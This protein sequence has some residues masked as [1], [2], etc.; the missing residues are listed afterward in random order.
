MKS[1]VHPK[2]KTKYRVKNWASYDRALVRRGDVTVWLSPEEVAVLSAATFGSLASEF[3]SPGRWHEGVPSRRYR[4]LLAAH[5]SWRVS[6]TFDTSNTLAV[7]LEASKSSMSSE[8]DPPT[9]LADGG[10]ENVNRNV[11]KL[12]ESGLLRAPN[13][14][15]VSTR[16]RT[17]AS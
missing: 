17:R 10:V 16:L 9:V 13:T 4:Q 8:S 3:S 11:D 15:L 5:P 2:Y 1:R 14:V 12:I 6:A 7:L